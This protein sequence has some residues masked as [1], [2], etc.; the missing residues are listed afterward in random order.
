MKGGLDPADGLT[1]M[2]AELVQEVA[3]TASRAGLD[4]GPVEFQVVP[5]R[6]L[7]SISAYGGLLTRLAH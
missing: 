4:S 2:T 7:E 5:G 1:T 3:A 6:V